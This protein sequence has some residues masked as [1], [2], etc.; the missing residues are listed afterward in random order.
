MKRMGGKIILSKADVVSDGFPK[1][2][3][4]VKAHLIPHAGK[5]MHTHRLAVQISVIIQQMSLAVDV[6]VTVHTGTDAHAGNSGITGIT[7]GA[8]TDVDAVA[9]NDMPCGEILIDGGDA[10]GSAQ[11]FSVAHRQT[12]GKRPTQKGGSCFHIAL[13]YG[14][15]DAG[16]GYGCIPVGNGIDDGEGDIR[17]GQKS[18]EIGGGAAS[19]VSES[20]IEATYHGGTVQRADQ[21]LP[22]KLL[23]GQIPHRGKIHQN[24]EIQARLGKLPQLFLCGGKGGRV[25]LGLCQRGKGPGAAKTSGNGLSRR[26][27]GA[28]QSAV[29]FVHAVEITQ[30]QSDGARRQCHGHSLRQ[31]VYRHTDLT[32][33]SNSQRVEEPGDSK[34]LTGTVVDTFVF[35][36]AEAEVQAR[37]DAGETDLVLPTASPILLGITKAALATESFMSAASFQETTKVLTDAAIHGKVDHLIGLKENVLIGKL[38]PAGSGL[39]A[40]RDYQPGET[41]ASR[42]PEE[43]VSPAIEA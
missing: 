6:T 29:S 27:G 2:V 33:E 22:H 11:F 17:F 23:R 20:E 32:R 43:P 30:S 10:D 40:Y 28:K 3:Q 26:T 25:G 21:V 37:I 34:L 31:A 38:I 19:P 1:C 4:G 14:F 16:R 41:P 42:L 39:M 18:A 15:A 13:G 12:N 35:E 8:K 36:D 9:G 7:Y 24:G 5:K